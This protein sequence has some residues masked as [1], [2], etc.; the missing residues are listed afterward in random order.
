MRN[1]EECKTEI[2]LRS[3]KRIKERKRNQIRILTCCV[4]I[5][6]CLFIT[7]AVIFPAMMQKDKY[8]PSP[9]EVQPP[10]ESPEEEETSK[11]NGGTPNLYTKIEITGNSPS[12]Y[13]STT[14]KETIYQTLNILKTAFEDQKNNNDAEKNNS[15]DI[16]EDEPDSETSASEFTITFSSE[17]DLYLSYTIT[18]HILKSS[19]GEKTAL[20]ADDIQKLK[21]I[22]T[23]ADT[24]Y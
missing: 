5:C 21:D 23:A 12:Q 7:S 18:G 24:E 22:I 20:T 1:L 11:L 2:F 4:P 15:D 9:E 14:N 16:Q 6:L 13:Y 3:E 17:N 8:S 10:L 19:S